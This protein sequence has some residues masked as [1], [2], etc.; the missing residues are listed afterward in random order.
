MP[1]AAS[2]LSPAETEI[3]FGDDEIFFSRTDFA[4]RILSCNGVFERISGYDRAQLVGAPHKIVRHRDTPRAVF[5]ALWREITAGRPIGAYVKNR[6]E[7]GACYWVFAIVSPLDDGYLSVRIRPEGAVFDKARGLYALIDS[8]ERTEKLTPADSFRLAEA[9]LRDEGFETYA[10]FMSAALADELAGRDARCGGRVDAGLSRLRDLDAAARANLEKMR[11]IKTACALSRHLPL[12]L[13]VQA[14]RL[15][16]GGASIASIA[17]NYTA[18]VQEL[19]G[20]MDAFES[21]ARAVEASVSEAL[22][23]Y[24]A[25]KVQAEMAEGFGQEAC[26]G[27]EA[28]VRDAAE[29]VRQS[30]LYQENAARGV[31]AIASQVRRFQAACADMKR[32]AAALEVTRIV[33]KVETARLADGEAGA[34]LR[35]LLEDLGDFQQTLARGLTALGQESETIVYGVDAVTRQVGRINPHPS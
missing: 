28:D 5:H 23:L 1:A 26:E 25:A 7:S 13:Q 8:R 31:E 2:V 21:T 30:R 29:L 35:G 12:N 3:H 10:A 32:L 34:G 15:G 9:L 17:G 19:A 11:A 33:G 27:R 24:G 20:C 14:A 4:G 18:I 16:A 6:A 22:F